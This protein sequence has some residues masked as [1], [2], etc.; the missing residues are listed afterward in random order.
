[1]TSLANAFSPAIIYCLLLVYIFLC[2]TSYNWNDQKIL[3]THDYDVLVQLYV[4]EW[5]AG[6]FSYV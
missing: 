1:M 6:L 2:Y 5:S 4:G 3:E